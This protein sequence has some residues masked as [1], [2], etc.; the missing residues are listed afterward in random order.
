MTGANDIHVKQFWPTSI[1]SR[2]WPDHSSE[3][4]ALIEL[5]YRI[6]AAQTKQ[7]ASGVAIG[8][9][10][11]QGLFESDFDLLAR[12]HPGLSRLKA[13]I[14]QSVQLAVSLVNGSTMDPRRLRVGIPDS[15][16]HITNDGG[17]HDAHRHGGCSWCGIYYLQVGDPASAANSGASNGVNRFYSPLPAGGIVRDYGNQYLEL[18]Y[19]DVPQ[20]DGLLVLFPSYLMHSGLP[21]RGDRDR[22][23]IS[24]NS[25]VTCE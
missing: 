5:M 6:K 10:S 2:V 7:I 13:F 1:F 23:I 3:S 15:W 9:K 12:D 18:N 24:F 14:G 22:I 17:F 25:Q 19:V 8:A 21:Y 20:R 4:P 16:C 11:S